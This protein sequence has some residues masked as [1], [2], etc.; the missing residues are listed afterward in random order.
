MDVVIVLDQL[1]DV[2]YMVRGGS[3]DQ[4]ESAAV[5]YYLDLHALGGVLVE[6]VAGSFQKR[7]E[8]RLIIVSFLYPLC[9]RFGCDNG[10]RVAVRRVSRACRMLRRC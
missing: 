2:G 5:G 3:P 9:A 4:V 8:A 10:Y 7:A 6:D 1:P